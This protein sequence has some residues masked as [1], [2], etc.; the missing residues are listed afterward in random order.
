MAT[1]CKIKPDYRYP[2]LLLC[3]IGFFI[4]FA[5]QAQAD[6]YLRVRKDGV[7]YYFFPTPVEKNVRLTDRQSQLTIL[8]R[9][10][11]RKVPPQELTPVVQEAGRKYN[12]PPALIKAVIQVE[13]N[14]NPGA[15][16]PKGAQGLMQLMP[17]TAADLQVADPYDIRE[18]ILA[19]TRYLSMLLHKFGHKLPH[20]L[21]AYNAGPQRIDRH[22]GVPPIV[23]TQD[24]VRNVCL[25]FL[26]YES[27]E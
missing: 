20:A 13:S 3:S 26:R 12:V 27:E 7:I 8:R 24:F 22:Q 2:L 10:P 23:E 4:I 19:G 5:P 25:H 9:A 17:A 18:N 14:F 6:G 1:P 15:V 16:S 21:A 11:L